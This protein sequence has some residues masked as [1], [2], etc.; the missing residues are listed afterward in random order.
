MSDDLIDNLYFQATGVRF[1]TAFQSIAS[2]GV[3]IIIGFIYSWK[4]AL[5]ILAFVP[6]IGVAGLLQ[7]KLMQGYSADGREALEGAGKVMSTKD[8][9]RLL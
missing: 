5:G 6:F 8:F 1:G 9:S 3:G 2:V 4:L 7:M